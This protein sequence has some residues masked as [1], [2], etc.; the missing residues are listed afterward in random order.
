MTTREKINWVL[1]SL[2]GISGVIGAYLQGGWK[3][4]LPA[5]GAAMG[6]L[7]GIN[8]YVATKA[9]TPATPAA[10]TAEQTTV[11]I[12]K[13]AAEFAALERAKQQAGK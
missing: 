4:A 13:L 3:M 5:F 11:L 12:N 7:A 10:P 9:S 1:L 6:T 8:G 2:A